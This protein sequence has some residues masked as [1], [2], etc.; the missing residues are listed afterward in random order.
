MSPSKSK[1]AAFL[2]PSQHFACSTRYRE[3]S[4]SL[5]CPRRVGLTAII[6]RPFGSLSWTDNV[7][8]K[9]TLNFEARRPTLSVTQAFLKSQNWICWF[10]CF[11]FLNSGD[12]HNI[13]F[14][15][16]LTKSNILLKTL[17]E[18]NSAWQGQGQGSKNL[19]TIGWLAVSVCID[20]VFSPPNRFAPS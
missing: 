3:T 7:S 11:D 4:E 13:G 12:T 15:A 16:N 1:S 8:V 17:K 9:S 19:S 2:E 18:R 6:V 20:S 14:V 10:V 5:L